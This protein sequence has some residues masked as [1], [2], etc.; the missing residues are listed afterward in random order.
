MDATTGMSGRLLTIG[1]RDTRRKPRED[2]VKGIR[3][4]VEMMKSF[5]KE[6]T[7]SEC[8][9]AKTWAELKCCCNTLLKKED[10]NTGQMTG[11]TKEAK[12]AK[13]TGAG[14]KQQ[15]AGRVG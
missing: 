8:Q 9:L 6:N 3:N 2:G 10:S 7:S 5:E 1:V 13:A 12:A 11:A 14:R 15:Q 4:P